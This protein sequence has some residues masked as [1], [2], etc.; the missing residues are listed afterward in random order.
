[1]IRSGWGNIVCVNIRSLLTTKW[2]TILNAQRLVPKELHARV[3]FSL[4]VFFSCFRATGFSCNFQWIQPGS[5]LLVELSDLRCTAAMRCWKCKLLHVCLWGGE[6]WLGKWGMGDGG[7]LDMARSRPTLGL[8]EPR[9][10]WGSCASGPHT[11]IHQIRTSSSTSLYRLDS[12]SIPAR[13][14]ILTIK[15]GIW[16]GGGD[17]WHIETFPSCLTRLLILLISS[18]MSLEKV[19][20][21]GKLHWP[22]IH[23]LIRSARSWTIVARAEKLFILGI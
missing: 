3:W 7:W 4:P 9:Q 6:G 8:K 5:A 16:S 12:R 1:M 18:T 20:T 21:R 10:Y 23:I 22:L 13:L 15:C 19:K 17:V 11:V 2:Q 14:E